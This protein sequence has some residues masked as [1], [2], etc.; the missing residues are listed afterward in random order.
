MTPPAVVITHGRRRA[1][2][3]GTR[4]RARGIGAVIALVL[5]AA[6]VLLSAVTGMPRPGYVARQLGRPVADAYRRAAGIPPP[7]RVYV[8]HPAHD[9]EDTPDDH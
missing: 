5:S 3:A 2:L 9:E 4:R 6:D 7:V 8:S 1:R